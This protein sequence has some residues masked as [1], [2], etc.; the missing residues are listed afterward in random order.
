[1]IH[2]RGCEE[3]VEQDAQKLPIGN[4]SRRST[5]FERKEGWKG[6]QLT[7]RLFAE[8]KKEAGNTHFGDGEKDTKKDRTTEKKKSKR[9]GRKEMKRKESN[10]HRDVSS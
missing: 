5:Q 10:I 4:P 3:H 2:L 8:K 1:M 7:E 6:C 9:G